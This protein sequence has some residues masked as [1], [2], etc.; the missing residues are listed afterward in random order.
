MNL[1][2]LE[3]R[4]DGEYCAGAKAPADVAECLTELGFKQI[5]LKRSDATTFIGKLWDK[6]SW[7]LCAVANALKIKK[8]SVVF[9]QYPRI[10]L[11]SRMGMKF[12][13]LLKKF[14]KVH[15]ISLV[16]D[17]N[18]L[19]GVADQ[20][21]WDD[22]WL[23]VN[24]SDAVIVHNENMRQWY[25]SKDVPEHKLVTLSIFDYLIPGFEP[26]PSIAFEKSVTLASNLIT[27]WD[28]GKFIIGLKNVKDVKWE[29]YGPN[30]DVETCGG[31]NV[32]Y[33]GCFPSEEAP[34]KLVKGFGLVWGGDTVE[35]CGG[36]WGEYFR[37][38]SPHRLSAYLVSGLPVVVW[39]KSGQAD[40]VKDN[41]VG[42]TVDSLM[43]I[44]PILG[45]MSDGEY[46]T[47]RKNALEVSKR[48]REGY[49]IKRATR[50][51][52]A[53]IG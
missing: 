4:R 46:Q 39:S 13:A 37:Y 34:K 3:E 53:R 50:E 32:H 7:L 19:R 22:L 45:K 44:G 42:I 36:V 21:D 11:W 41:G 1:Y 33:N 30:F 20:R 8:D 12:F 51:A 10:F 40:F 23:V 18:E 48:L 47:M 25:L 16:H 17:I 26:I 29:L 6:I 15:Y 49:Y 31:E 5:N 43:Q 28:R 52:L 9:V 14:R 27:K 24:L 35:T 2:Q 38:I